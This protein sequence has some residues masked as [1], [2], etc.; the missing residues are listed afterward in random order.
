VRVGKVRYIGASNLAAW[1]LMKA[2]GISERE[3]LARFET[4]QAYYSVAGRDLERELV[5][6][7]EAEKVGLLVWS[8]LAGGFL[9][10]KFT[11]DNRQPQETR[12][13]S[14][15]FPPVDETRGWSALDALGAVAKE[16]SVSV[17]RVALAWLLHR[18]FTTSV[19]IGARNEGQL[20]DNLAAAELR[21]TPAQLEL[22][23][24]ATALPSEYP[25]WIIAFQDRDRLEAIS[26]EKRFANVS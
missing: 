2:L 8:P 5:P 3:H 13:A 4:L 18:P 26:Q 10:G 11:R 7:M 6:L 14:F 22:I 16:Q 9:S 12:R 23:G 17:A 20:R 15:Q 19:I 1:Q 25:G 21:L 24:A